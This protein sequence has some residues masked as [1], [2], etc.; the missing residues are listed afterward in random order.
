LVKR[1]RDLYKAATEASKNAVERAIESGKALIDLRATQK[2]EHG[3]WLAFLQIH[4][5]E[6]SERT[7]QRHM[8]LAKAHA[9][10]T[11][12]GKLKEK[13]ATMADLTVVG[14]E[15]LLGPENRRS[16]GS[17]NPSDAYDSTEKKLIEKLKKLAPDDAE[18][19]AVETIK[20]LNETVKTMKMAAAS[21]MKK[22]PAQGANA[23]PASVANAA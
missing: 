2:V 1:V 5:P 4:L 16:S 18:A 10:G 19:A 8:R 11:L 15:E 14:A 23:A 20:Q 22:V 17:Q 9:D 21:A 6:V 7:A 3:E 12:E 13:S